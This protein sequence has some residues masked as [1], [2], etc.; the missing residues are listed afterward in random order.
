VFNISIVIYFA[1]FS[2]VCNADDELRVWFVEFKNNLF[3]SNLTAVY[4]FMPFQ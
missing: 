2:A 1:V 4:V 3:E